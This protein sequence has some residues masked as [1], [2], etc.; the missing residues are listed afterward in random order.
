M[1]QLMV[2]FIVAVVLAFGAFHAVIFE[3]SAGCAGGCR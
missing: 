1:K 3:V 2:S